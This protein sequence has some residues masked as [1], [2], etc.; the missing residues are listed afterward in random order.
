M[1]T[2]G[3]AD[4]GE[5]DTGGTLTRGI[6]GRLAG[7]GRVPAS[8]RA[9]LDHYAATGRLA[10][11]SIRAH[12]RAENR[13]EETIDTAFEEVER[14]IATEFDR[15]AEAV[16]FDY[17]TK[18][19]MPVELT[20]AHVYVRSSNP[21]DADG[22]E[23]PVSLSESVTDLVV[24]ALLDGDVR[25]ALNDAE[26]GDFEV[27]FKL[28][29]RDERQR[30]AEIAQSTLQSVVDERFAGF[31]DDVRNAYDRAVDFSEAHQ[32]RDPYFRE[33]FVDAKD[34]DEEALA[35]I[36][37]EYKFA[38]FAEPPELVAQLPEE[39]PYFKTQ[40]GR[41][42]VIYDGM[43]DMYRAA[44]VPIDPA[45][46]L[47]IVLS[48][49]GAQI[50]LDDVDDYDHDLADDQLTPV[51]GEYLLAESDAAAYDRVVEI[52]ERYLQAAKDRALAADSDLV[53][54]GARYIYFSGEPTVL[55]R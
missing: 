25:D 8:L 48:I 18:L 28:E 7:S 13:I 10:V 31:D 1:E 27:N 6:A 29:G 44:G 21:S 40:Y 45:F 26:Y 2:H 33:L 54:I 53:S 19:T 38:S 11:D 17:G 4:A 12:R 55:P 41:V 52:T 42:G 47:S 30:V 43:I 15:D 35:A 23:D 24:V 34:G 22:V 3:T 36:R 46:E 16:E 51:T 39:L 49:I 32:E 37:E 20:L 9:A 14:A 50:W 5:S